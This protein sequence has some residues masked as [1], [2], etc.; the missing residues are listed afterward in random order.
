MKQQLIRFSHHQTW[1]LIP[2]VL[3]WVGSSQVGIFSKLWNSESAFVLVFLANVA[4]HIQ[5]FW[6]FLISAK[7]EFQ[8]FLTI[9]DK[10]IKVVGFVPDLRERCFVELWNLT[11][12]HGGPNL[13]FCVCLILL[14]ALTGLDTHMVRA[15]EYIR[16]SRLEYNIS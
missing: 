16:S 13:G 11:W 9:T 4:K 6:Q 1:H 15:T 3:F 7:N 5:L 2:D 14:S 10:K 8:F 12:W